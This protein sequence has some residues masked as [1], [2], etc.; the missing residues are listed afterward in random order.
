MS[1]AADSGWDQDFAW[2]ASQQLT[3]FKWQSH[4]RIDEPTYALAEAWALPA[5]AEGVSSMR[6]EV[7]RF[8]AAQGALPASWVY[9]HIPVPRLPARIRVQQEQQL[10]HVQGWQPCRVAVESDP[11]HSLAGVLMQQRKLQA[12]DLCLAGSVMEGWG[13]TVWPSLAGQLTSLR[14]TLDPHLF[15]NE[16]ACLLGG[17]CV[18]VGGCGG[19][20]SCARVYALW[21]VE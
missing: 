9:C 4:R 8:A 10:A 21:S 7:H 12:L 6:Q 18:V 11:L 15:S 19:C 13:S 1:C 17:V 14:L 3:C 5:C 20:V 2:L 16:G